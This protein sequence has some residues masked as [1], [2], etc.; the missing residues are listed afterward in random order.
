MS[1]FDFVTPIRKSGYV[2]G[3]VRCN[4]V[5]MGYFEDD[6]KKRRNTYKPKLK[7]TLE[8]KNEVGRLFKDVLDKAMKEDE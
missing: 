3:I 6:I 4:E 7:V 2:E 1:D 8:H 5:I